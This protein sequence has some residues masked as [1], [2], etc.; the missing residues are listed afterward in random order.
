M[1]N[2]VA[3]SRDRPGGRPAAD[4]VRVSP[5]G[6]EATGATV[7]ESPSAPHCSPGWSTCG[8]RLVSATIHRKDTP[9]ESDGDPSSVAVTVTP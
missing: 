6:S 2:P 3:G 9:E 8:A 4:Q 1:I 7:T 5:S